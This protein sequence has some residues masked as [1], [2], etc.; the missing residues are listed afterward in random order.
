MPSSS[1]SVAQ[2]VLVELGGLEVVGVVWQRVAQHVER[3]VVALEVLDQELRVL[4][5]QR[6]AL[7]GRDERSGSVDVTTLPSRSPSPSSR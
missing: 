4:D 6:V 2:R 3:V 7:G 1:P 5:A